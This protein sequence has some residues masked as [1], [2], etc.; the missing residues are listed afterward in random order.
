MG[1]VPPWSLLR[2]KAHDW[3]IR[4]LE[5]VGGRT[6]KV[7]LLLCNLREAISGETVTRTKETCTGTLTLTHRAF[8]TRPLAEGPR[9]PVRGGSRLYCPLPWYAG[10]RTALMRLTNL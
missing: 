2:R 4:L 10:Y 1:K 5:E 7:P 9:P 6:Q 8:P 3:L